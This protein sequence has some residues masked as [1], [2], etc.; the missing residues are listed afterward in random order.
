MG[1]RSGTSLSH[2]IGYSLETGVGS[3]EGFCF[4]FKSLSLLN[5]SAVFSPL[6][7]GSNAFVKS[8]MVFLAGS[9]AL[10]RSE[11]SLPQ[12]SSYWQRTISLV[13]G[14]SVITASYFLLANVGFFLS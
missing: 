7:A 12:S 14:G 5:Y 13:V 3:T 11:F 2:L 8:S 9:K 4:C 1:V 10:W 6:S